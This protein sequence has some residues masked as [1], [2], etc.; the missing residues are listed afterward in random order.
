MAQSPTWSKI[1]RVRGLDRRSRHAL[2]CMLTNWLLGAFTWECT[3]LA[4]EGLS[5]YDRVNHYKHAQ[6]SL[7]LE[8]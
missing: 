2:T 5:G 6:G 8:R 1:T 4:G 7:R 3:G